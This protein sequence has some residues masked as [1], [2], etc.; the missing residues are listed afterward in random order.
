MLSSESRIRCRFD[1]TVLTKSLSLNEI[2]DENL[3]R[4]RLILDLHSKGYTDNEISDYLNKN[5]ILTPTG[6]KYYYDLVFVTRRKLRLRDIRKTTFS[7]ELGKL[8]FQ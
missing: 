1:V 6:K 2:P 3:S 5:N 8:V 7:Y 4:H